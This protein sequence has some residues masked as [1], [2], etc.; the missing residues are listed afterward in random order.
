MPCSGKREVFD[1]RSRRSVSRKLLLPNLLIDIIPNHT[2][3]TNQLKSK[4]M[5]KSRSEP[6]LGTKKRERKNQEED[7]TNLE[8]FRTLFPLPAKGIDM[9]KETARDQ[10]RHSDERERSKFAC[11]SVRTCKSRNNFLSSTG[12]SRY[13]LTP[14][15]GSS[16]LKCCCGSVCLSCTMP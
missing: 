15:K 13:R 12:R 7:S 6:C 5:S 9:R 1:V 3:L 10:A 2:L 11:T 16:A 14:V 8:P 4:G